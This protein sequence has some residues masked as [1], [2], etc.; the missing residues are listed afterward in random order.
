MAA[1]SE[2]N[3][4]RNDDREY[5]DRLLV[6]NVNAAKAIGLIIPPA[7]LVRADEVIE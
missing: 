5:S 2:S 7:L 6:V 3:S 4:R 1:F